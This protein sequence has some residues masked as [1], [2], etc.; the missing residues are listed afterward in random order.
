MEGSDEVPKNVTK[1]R[2]FFQLAA[3]TGVGECVCCLSV[4]HG[5]RTVVL[6]KVCIGRAAATGLFNYALCGMCP[7][8]CCVER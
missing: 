8:L 6:I 7:V 2:Y 4:L 3:E 1:A 5:V